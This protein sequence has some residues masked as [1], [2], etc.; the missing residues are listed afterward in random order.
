[1][2]PREDL[3]IAG[4]ADWVY[5][6]WVP[7]CAGLS[8]ARGDLELRTV[9]LDL[10]REVLVSGL[11]VAGEVTESGHVPFDLSPETAADRIRDEWISAWGL[12]TPAPGAVAWLD[13]TAA[14]DAVA[15]RALARESSADS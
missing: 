9:A 3:L 11:M 14:G 5:V 12:E 2:T 8:G 6:G 15:Q 1:M 4:L 10:I 13:N 7:V